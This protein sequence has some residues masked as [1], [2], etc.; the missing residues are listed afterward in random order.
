[1]D[2]LDLYQPHEFCQYQFE[3]DFIRELMDLRVGGSDSQPHE[4]TMNE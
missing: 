3:P 2:T 4:F 1:M